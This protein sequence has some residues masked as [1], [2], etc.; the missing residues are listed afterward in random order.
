MKTD[1]AKPI[2]DQCPRCYAK[3]VSG[4]AARLQKAEAQRDQLAA[5]VQRMLDDGQ[6]FLG[7]VEA[8]NRDT[9]DF[10][11][12]ERDARAVMASIKG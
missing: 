11:Q 3:F 12:W 7:A 6:F 2:I 4:A 5:L 1:Y 10:E 8:Q 9:S